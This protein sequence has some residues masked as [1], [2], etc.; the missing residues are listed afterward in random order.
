MAGSG[1]AYRASGH[2]QTSMLLF[3]TVNNAQTLTYAS[4]RFCTPRVSTAL[5]SIFSS[6][7][8]FSPPWVSASKGSEKKSRF[9]C[10]FVGSLKFLRCV[11]IVDM[12]V[13]RRP[14]VH[15]YGRRAKNIWNLGT[16]I[17]M[18]GGETPSLS[19]VHDGDDVQ[20]RAGTGRKRSKEKDREAACTL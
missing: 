15:W 11:D 8:D 3:L 19:A 6:S 13:C 12:V 5:I 18:R 4:S 16:S 14:A 20:T 9:S 17:T 1:A 7:S 2:R 10:S